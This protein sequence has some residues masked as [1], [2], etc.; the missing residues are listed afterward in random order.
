M[1]FFRILFAVIF[2]YFISPVVTFAQEQPLINDLN[3]PLEL[4][5]PVSCQLEENCWLV[6]YPDIVSGEGA[7]DYKMGKMTYEGSMGIDI[8]VQT[9]LDLKNGVP[10]LSAEDGEVIFV[11]NDIEDNY[12]LGPKKE[13]DN[14]PFC[15]NFVVIRHT[16]DWKTVYCHL[17]KDSIEV[18]P[19]DFALEGRKIAEI[20]LSGKTEFPHLYF[21]VLYKKNYY[22]PFSGLELSE[23]PRKYK[24]FW[25]PSVKE[26]L[27]YKNFAIINIGVSKE[28]P[29]ADEVKKGEYEN[30]EIF[31]DLSEIYVWIHGF[32]FNKDD[33]LKVS[34]SNPEQEKILDDTVK[35]DSG[36]IERFFVFKKQKKEE[37]TWLPGSYTVKAEL[38]SPDSGLAYKYD[39]DFEIK[40]LPEPIDEEALRKEKLMEKYK[41]QRRKVI[42]FHK[43]KQEGK[44]P[45]TY[46]ENKFKFEFLNQ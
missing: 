39:F 29:S 35:I 19:G 27:K 40:K 45:D 15:G 22:D 31:N 11:R 24:S 42:I 43:L 33:F 36:E 30:I 20:G 12:P 32:H 10:V 37:K 34:V 7:A 21:S 4:K 44:L 17:K 2:I 8:A 28:A 41:L 5:F 46:K 16:N 9:V 18:E 13:N 6:N 14:S 1:F 26:N 23:D 25:A 38:I 3:P